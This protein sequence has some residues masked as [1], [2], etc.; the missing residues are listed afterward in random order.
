VLKALWWAGDLAVVRRRKFQPEYDL[1]ERVI[2][3]SVRKAPLPKRDGIKSLLLQALSGHGWARTG[4]LTRTW[5]IRNER[6][7]VGAC[8]EELRENGRVAPCSLEGSRGWIRP[9][10]LELAATLSRL[11]PR[12][13]RGVLLSPFDPVVWDRARAK[14]LFDFEPILEIFK[15]AHQRRYGYYCMPVLAGER[16]VARCDLKADRRAGRLRVLS[17]HD[18]ASSPVRG[19][20]VRHALERHARSLALDL[21]LDFGASGA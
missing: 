11:R 8:L 10:D 3:D 13:D 20:A 14:T 19:A 4:T 9:E 16:L 2:P 7:L 15:P 18:E 1:A 17:V 5:R 21:D 12:S 6:E